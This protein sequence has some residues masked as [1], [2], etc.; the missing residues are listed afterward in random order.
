MLLDP[1]KKRR[2]TL[3]Y[4]KLGVLGLICRDLAFT[5]KSGLLFLL[6]NKGVSIKVS[7]CCTLQPCH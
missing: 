5:A 3:L 1:P 2:L 6:T 7:F 4:P